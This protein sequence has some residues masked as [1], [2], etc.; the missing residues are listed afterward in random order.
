MQKILQKLSELKNSNQPG[1]MT[2]VVAG[3]PNL[4]D[5]KK[6][7]LAMA[8][9]GADF[10]EIQIPFSDPIADGPVILSANQ[11]ALD[12]KIKV[13]DSFKLMRE[14][15]AQLPETPLLFMTYFNLLFHHGV[16]K[17]CHEATLAGASGFIVP[18]LPVEEAGEYLTACKKYHLAPI[19]VAAPNTTNA[20]LKKIAEV[21][22]GFLYVTARTGVTGVKTELSKE[23]K[24]CLKNIKS[25]IKLPLAVGFGI[26]SADQIQA[27]RGYADI[28][29]VGSAALRIL[30]QEGI[31]GVG[32]FVEGLKKLT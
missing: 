4:M 6:L 12:Q 7:V 16:E 13:A 8:K 14:L 2:H 22:Q 17:F 24:N 27:L 21:A 5:T 29:V 1:L 11:K 25:I 19:F 9:A 31:T 30:D 10:V 28:A 23:L 15:S 26:Q 20:R 18:D 3:Y 32:R